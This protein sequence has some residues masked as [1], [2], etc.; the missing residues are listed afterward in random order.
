MTLVPA[1]NLNPLPPLTP[2]PQVSRE[3]LQAFLQALCGGY[4][5]NPYH[6]W[7]HAVGVLHG[8]YLMQR[9]GYTQGSEEFKLSPLQMLSL[10]VAALGHDIDHP[11]VSNAFLIA[12]NAPLALCYNDESVLEN[13]HAA[14]TFGL[15]QDDRLNVLSGLTPEQRKEARLLIVKSILATDM[16]HHSE[17]IRELTEIAAQQRPVRALDVMQAYLHLADLSNPVL[18]W[19][20][21]KRWAALVCGEF[22][23]QAA[24][25]TAAGLPVAPHLKCFA[26][27]ASD[28]ELD[29]ANLQLGFID[30]VVAPLWNAAALLL[31]AAKERIAQLDQNR[32]SWQAEKERLTAAAA[33][34]AAPAAARAK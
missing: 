25:E 34:A 14:T 17:M 24:K 11:G 6:N 18:E 3:R 2:P 23:N 9:Q 27:G 20:L 7:Q 31:P 32:A 4:H 8:C 26:P 10:F 21:S 22:R 5:A 28:N 12:S 16:A 29:V 19:S 33:S 1:P 13:H 30:F 15:L